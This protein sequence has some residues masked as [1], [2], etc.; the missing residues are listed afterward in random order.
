MSLDP[1]NEEFEAVLD[2]GTCL[3]FRPVR[4]DDKDRIASGLRRLSPS[5][6]YLRFFSYV[7][8]LSQE[9]LRYLT[10]VDFQDH[11]A[12]IA[13]LPDAPAEPGVGI[14]R[15]IRLTDHAHVA[16][17]AVTVLDE[18]Q[19]RGIGTALLWLLARS[20]IARDVSAFRVEVMGE[21]RPMIE[22]LRGLGAVRGE[23]EGGVAAFEIPLTEPDVGEPPARLVLKAVAEGLGDLG[24]HD[25]TR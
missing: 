9:Q 7:D 11:F 1:R 24:D 3:R 21:N 15:W 17:A 13:T 20:A 16:E 10:E 19:H 14:A 22:L 6:R 4:P 12:W 2:D 18:F 5:S 25:T 23:W 8:H